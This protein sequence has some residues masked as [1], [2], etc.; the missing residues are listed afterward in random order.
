MFVFSVTITPNTWFCGGKCVSIVQV[1]FHRYS[2]QPATPTSSYR[3]ATVPSPLIAWI[4]SKFLLHPKIVWPTDTW[5]IGSRIIWTS[6]QACSLPRV[7]NRYDARHTTQCPADRSGASLLSSNKSRRFKQVTSWRSVHW[8]GH[9]TKH[10][11]TIIGWYWYR[12]WW[13]GMVSRAKMANLGSSYVWL[14]KIIQQICLV[15]LSS[16]VVALPLWWSVLSSWWELIEAIK[17][18]TH[19]I[20]CCA[21]QQY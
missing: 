16:D 15:Q 17:S 4:T 11:D 3:Q 14:Y 12:I 5:E 9:H 19:I 13:I 8:T 1:T 21:H 20:V 6:R 10:A 18:M 7:F 2:V